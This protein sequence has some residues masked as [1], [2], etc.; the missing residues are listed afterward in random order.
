VPPANIMT[1]SS[2]YLASKSVMEVCHTNL[3]A[4][5][6]VHIIVSLSSTHHPQLMKLVRSNHK[7]MIFPAKTWQP[8]K[9]YAGHMG[10]W[11]T[12]PLVK[13]ACNLLHWTLKY[14]GRTNAAKKWA[15]M[16]DL[17]TNHTPPS[18]PLLCTHTKPCKWTLKEVL[19]R[20]CDKH[21]QGIATN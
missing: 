21:G 14:S 5:S 13:P 11:S 16:T 17:D 8:W 7:Q 20:P 18:F 15:T 3:L 10:R 12:R 1:E 4:Q 2:L 19:K 6:F 9:R